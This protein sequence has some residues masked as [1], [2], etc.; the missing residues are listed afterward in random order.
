[1][2]G[3]GRRSV[4]VPAA[5]V[6]AAAFAVRIVWPLSD[7]PA[8]LSWSDG[9]YT[10]PAAVTH[11]AR[12]AALFG[13]WVRD[14][15]RDLV[16]YPLLNGITWAAYRILGVS[17]L[18]TQLL[19]ALLGTL[20]V[21]GL[22][23]AV[24][25]GRGRGAGLLVGAAAAVSFWLAMFSRVPIAE[26]LVAAILALACVA[27]TARGRAGRFLAGF[28]AGLAGLF[29]KLHGLVFLP[30]LLVFLALRDRRASS[31]LPAVAGFAVV[32]AAWVI[33][34]AVPFRA[35]LADQVHRGEDLYG[36]IPLLRS[37]AKAVGEVVWT[38]RAPWLFH[39]MPVLGA[40]GGLF[41][42]GT[43]LA[44]GPR[45]RR[46]E[47]GTALFAL[48]FAAAW[49]LFT[50]L[51]YKAPRYFVLAAVPLVAAGACALEELA[52]SPGTLRP[53][54]TPG[55]RVVAVWLL[56][57][58]LVAVDVGI[59]GLFVLQQWLRPASAP[60]AVAVRNATGI[61]EALRPTATHL[62]LGLVLGGLAGLLS[63]RWPVRWRVPRDRA[64]RGLA[65]A[66]LLLQGVQLAGWAA[67]RA[68]ALE[69]T[70]RSLEAITG[71]DA[72]IFG[73][74]APA[75]VQDSRRVAVPLFGTPVP[76]TVERFGVTHV[77]LGSRDEGAAMARAEP[78]AADRMVL[79]RQWS[80]R[81]LRGGSIQL[82]RIRDTGY[83]PTPFER[84]AEAL[85][86]GRPADA[87][88]DFAAQRAS[89]APPV[90]DVPASE[91][92]CWYL[93]GDDERARASLREAIALRPDDPSAWFNLGVLLGEAG[94]RDGAR[95][96]WKRCLALDPWSKD[97]LEAM[98]ALGH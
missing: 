87:L 14:D 68:H 8:R 55:T 19:A 17:R 24:G 3:E 5:L 13:E 62:A 53:A 34:I 69:E 12:N 31:A 49:I 1:V 75:L 98:R 44:S 43:L 30:A 47:D 40:L 6:L 23:W 70:K 50:I 56:V 16:F 57:S 33:V 73:T 91:A 60:I 39:R 10:D 86:E 66:V 74:F 71:P 82:Q 72:V 95:A 48:W 58:G 21:A 45:R 42:T 80:L 93:L 92:R 28:L 22:A 64:V 90:P 59:H 81:L 94:D 25:R 54:G 26:N 41:V 18:T 37:P 84:G 97:A 79:V 4:V 78:E 27:A 63:W 46:L 67:R 85:A 88:E 76:G 15:S 7:P 9:V 36:T 29:G 38:L 32:A 2:S 61:V 77:V 11:A 52:R 20:A 65:V 89:G 96:A 35:E 83:V 51:P